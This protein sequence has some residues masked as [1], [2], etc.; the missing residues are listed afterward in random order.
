LIAGQT[1]VS[2]SGAYE[3]RS[4]STEAEWA[5]YHRIRRTV[6]FE[7]R[8]RIGAYDEHHPDERR[9]GN[10]PLLLLYDGEPVGVVRVDVDQ[11]RATFRRV[12]VREDAQRLGHGRTLLALAEA[13]A[14]T[15][16]CGVAQSYVDPG[17]VGFYER[18]GFARVSSEATAGTAVLM[19]KDLG[20]RSIDAAAASASGAH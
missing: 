11:G 18:C 12:A 15:E 3:L 20:S 7:A 4:P 6:L 5:A 13:F 10:H 16:R 9:P 2:R 19:V 17:A 14:R 1:T 8:G